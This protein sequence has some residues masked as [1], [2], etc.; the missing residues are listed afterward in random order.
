MT[1][2][3]LLPGQGGDF[4]QHRMGM[5]TDAVPTLFIYLFLRQGL[6]Q[7]V[8][9][10]LKLTTSPKMTLNFHAS[11]FHLPVLQIKAYA[12]TPGLCGAGDQNEGFL[13]A[14]QVLY[15]IEPHPLNSA[16]GQDEPSRD[17][18]VGSRQ[19]VVS[20]GTASPTLVPIFFSH[21]EWGSVWEGRVTELSG[22]QGVLQTCLSASPKYVQFSSIRQ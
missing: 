10:G 18:V 21:W 5:G 14:R 11:C 2:D 20:H 12:T 16:C 8:Q 1:S 4:S 15:Q 6:V 22:L 19:L 9:A 13:H 3:C 17:S 7:S